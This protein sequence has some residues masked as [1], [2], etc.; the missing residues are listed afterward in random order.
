MTKACFGVAVSGIRITTIDI[1]PQDDQHVA[2]E[3]E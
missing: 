2:L 1:A 3:E